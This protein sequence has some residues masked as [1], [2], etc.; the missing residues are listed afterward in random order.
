MPHQYNTVPQYY[1]LLRSVIRG[2]CNIQHTRMSI[3]NEI[4][5]EVEL[6]YSNKRTSRWIPNDGRG[7]S[8]CFREN[9]NLWDPSSI[10]GRDSVYL[11]NNEYKVCP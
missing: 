2:I 10:P 11:S 4:S 5:T 1:H 7:F 9:I 8:L 6:V 3:V